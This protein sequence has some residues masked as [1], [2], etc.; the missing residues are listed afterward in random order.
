MNVVLDGNVVTARFA[1]TDVLTPTTNSNIPV[2]C[3]VS[4]KKALGLMVN[5]GAI[6]ILLL[7][8]IRSTLVGSMFAS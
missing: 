7:A 1:S 4:L 6:N 3:P 8:G 5:V 2:F